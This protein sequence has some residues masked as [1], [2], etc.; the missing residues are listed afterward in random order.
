MKFL[1]NLLATIT[2]LAIFF[3]GVLPVL[4][5][6]IGAAMSS[7][8]ENKVT[9]VAE[10]SI[11]KIKLNKAVRERSKKNPFEEFDLPI[12]GN[13]SV[14]LI[15]IKEAL[16]N[17]KTDSNIE[18]IYLDL[19]M[20]QAG[21]A[22]LHEIHQA[23]NDFKNSGKFI[24]AYSQM[25]TE[26]SYYLA[27]TADSI[28]LHPQGF[29]EFNGLSANR[30]FYK[31]L[32]EKLGVT[33][34]IYKVGTYK[35]AVEPYLLDKMS[36]PSRTQTEIYLNALYDFYLKNISED[37]GIAFDELEN[38][39]D[40]MLVRKTA[41]AVQ[42]HLADRLSYYDEVQTS[43]KNAVAI[44][45]DEKLNFIS[46]KK[47][48]KAEKTVEKQYSSNK[49]AVIVA[50]GTIISGKA[51]EGTIS[52]DEIAKEIR[53]AREND[54]IKAVILRINSPGG[55]ALASDVMWREVVLTQKVKPII[56]SMSDVAASGGYYMAMACDTIIAQPNTITG[57]IGIFAMLFQTKGFFNDKLGITFDEVSTGELSNLGNPNSSFSPAQDAFFQEMINEGYENFTSKA[58]EG[59]GMALADLKK[60]AEGRVWSGTDAKANGLVD[61]L[62]SFND[63]VKIASEMAE[64]GDDY[65]LRYYPKQKSF[66]EDFIE[67]SESNIRT[68]MAKK[69]LGTFYP[70][71]KKMQ[72]LKKLEGIQARLPYDLV[73]E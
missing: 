32:F 30:M 21:F 28:F 57:S 61:V 43:L 29:V 5:I 19:S 36:D 11:L 26:K 27:A 10:N 37:R 70:L 24:Y 69:E 13:E 65:Q 47:Y 42:H 4:L 64:L 14:G 34:K 20:V 40:K 55:S 44:S 59:R 53:K 2:G 46:L 8:G 7:A 54:N 12:S 73:I 23:L 58:A 16:E 51:Q 18:G 45:E 22:T 72:D 15:D 38:I 52:G 56:A 39:S 50:E 41:D 25:L 3:L 49:I 60:V 9:E 68:E 6:G 67:Q 71:F 17:A 48:L 1:R 31:G 63:A 35:S 66:L 33:P 62:G